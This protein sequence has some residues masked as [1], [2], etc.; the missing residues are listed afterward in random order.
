MRSRLLRSAAPARFR[1][2]AAAL[3][4]L[5]VAGIVLAEFAGRGHAQQN[6]SFAAPGRVEGA[7]PPFSIGVAAAA[8]V[9]EVLVH[10]GSR[11][12]AGDIL[13]RL[14]CRPLRAELRSRQARLRA[15][16][17]TYGRVKNGSRP[18]EIV[19][20]EAIVGYSQA[21]AEEAQ[22]AL[23][24]AEAL[25]EGVTVTTA[26]V[27][28]V[29]RD[30]RITAAQLAEARARLSL[31]RAGSREEDIRHAEALRDAAVADVET[32]RAQL[33]QCSVRAPVDG[34]VLDVAI[35]TGQYLSTAV[36][37]PL[38]HL[39]A[40]GP[41][42]V[43]AKIEL[44]DAPRLCVGESAT[45]LSEVSPAGPV[46]RAEVTA[47]SA[48]VSPRTLAAG[49]EGHGSDVAGVMLTLDQGAPL[50]PIGAPATVRFDPCAPKT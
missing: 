48:G 37:Q 43:R 46:L 11:V 38:V 25:Q 20:G 13:V 50:L 1:V 3:G 33:A 30:A 26:R 27:L 34:V 24:R 14:D 41:Q 32:A 47:I 23:D 45:V 28:E 18:D 31:L 21:K 49:H 16:V 36:P 35:N 44:R 29:K 22:K 42:R 39:V 17:A 4:A 2:V 5:I 8:T 15:A 10:P 6:P 12:H 40:D 9:G 19:V 7:S